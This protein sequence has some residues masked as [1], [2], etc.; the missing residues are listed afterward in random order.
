MFVR[1]NKKWASVFAL[2][3]V[4]SLILSACGPTPTPEVI[5][6]V[7]TKVVKETVIVEGTPQ[8]VEKEVTRVVTATPMP[9]PKVLVVGHHIDPDNLEPFSNTTAA[10]QSVTASTIEQLVMFA[11]DGSGI[12]PCLAESWNWSD[13][14][15]TLE[16]KLREG[17]KF[18]NGED[19]NAEAAKFNI[20]LLMNAKAYS[21]WVGEF[22]SVEVVD[23]NTVAIHFTEPAG[24]AL[25]V[26]ARGGYVY[27]PKYYQE[28]GAEG[29]GSK[30]VG[31]GPYQFVEWVK[32]DHITCK[33]FPDYWGGTPKLDE[34]VWR[35][36]PEQAARVAA[37]QTGEVHLITNVV[38]GSVDQIEAD[39]NL[40]LF[41]IPGLRLFV[42]FFDMRLD[43][44][45]ADAKVRR[46][47]NYAVDKQGLVALFDGQAT[48]LH[49][50]YMAPGVLGYNPDLD[51]FEYDPEKAEEL[52]AEAGYPDGFEM[53]LKYTVNRYPLDAEMGEAVASY[54]EAVG[55]KVERVPLEYGEFKRQFYEE[56]MGPTMQWGLLDPPD[57]HIMLSTFDKGS[58]FTRFP[59]NPRVF[60]LLAEGKRESD[61]KKREKIYQELLQI[62]NEDPLGIYLLVPNDLYAIRE[63]VIGFEPR[64][65]QVVDLRNVDLMQ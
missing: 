24:Y 55:I 30:P 64:V 65:D 6:K 28:V 10:F 14:S 57:P 63:G 4:G 19:W 31:T 1:K 53:P 11:P 58:R 20:E 34:I 59:D 51:P 21:Y 62:W 13:D 23:N 38:P 50:Q 29:F 22:E 15:K 37:L 8:V 42:T 45:V 26:L 27:A 3:I 40:E 9:E 46:A 47:L 36:I 35:V 56:S 2:L 16:L 5:E 25:A 60:G 54:L 39:P 18:H 7:V 17:V 12:Q 33:A 48:A 32:D 43:H 41:S 44:P 49:G 61:P 52:L